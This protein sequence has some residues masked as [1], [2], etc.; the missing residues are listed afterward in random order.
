MFLNCNISFSSMPV[1]L[2]TIINE[3]VA[4]P[5]SNPPENKLTSAAPEWA[6]PP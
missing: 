3:Y 4:H 6:T 5:L 1:F 2:P